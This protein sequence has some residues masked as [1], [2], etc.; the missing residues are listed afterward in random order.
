MKRSIRQEEYEKIN[1]ID[2]Q[3]INGGKHYVNG[4]HCDKHTCSVHWS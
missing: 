2:L 1:P 3:K 4:V